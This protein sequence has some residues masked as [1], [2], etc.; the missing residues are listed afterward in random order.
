MRGNYCL[1]LIFVFCSIGEKYYGRM[2]AFPLAGTWQRPQSNPR[3]NP[4]NSRR[5]F[6][7]QTWPFCCLLSKSSKKSFEKHI[8]VQNKKPGEK[9]KKS[10]QTPIHVFVRVGQTAPDTG[11]RIR[12]PSD[13]HHSRSHRERREE[14]CDWALMQRET[15]C[16]DLP[17]ADASVIVNTKNL[18][19]KQIPTWSEC[20]E[21][22]YNYMNIA[23]FLHFQR[24]RYLVRLTTTR[25]TR[26]RVREYRQI[27]PWRLTP[28]AC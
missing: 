1:V 16:P 27:Q 25:I 10:R 17:D 22:L 18:R 4:L 13:C 20:K 3:S 24:N 7:D 28:G 23:R 2:R 5:E 6:V 14:I 15:T 26:V 11:G 21:R 9:R 8:P 12:T 19:A